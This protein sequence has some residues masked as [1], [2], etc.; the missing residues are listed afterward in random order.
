MSAEKR[1]NKGPLRKVAETTAKVVGLTAF[2][3]VF[4]PIL[5]YQVWRY[6]KQDACKRD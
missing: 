3:T 1:K 5:A 4:G 6:H 2:W